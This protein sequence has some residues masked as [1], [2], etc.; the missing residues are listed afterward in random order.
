MLR[1]KSVSSQALRKGDK[2]PLL[3]EHDKLLKNTKGKMKS[4]ELI[5]RIWKEDLAAEK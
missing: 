4:A 1:E 2:I 5:S 3:K